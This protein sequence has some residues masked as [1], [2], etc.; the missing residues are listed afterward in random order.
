MM[1]VVRFR[2]R[3]DQ[4]VEHPHVDPRLENMADLIDGLIAV[5]DFASGRTKDDPCLHPIELVGCFRRAAETI[6]FWTDT[7]LPVD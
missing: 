1:D 4:W 2:K 5:M 6:E 3:P 7:S